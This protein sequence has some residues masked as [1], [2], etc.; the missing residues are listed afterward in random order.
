MLTESINFN[1][2]QWQS[3]LPGSRSKIFQQNGRQLRLVEFTSEFIEPDWC[4]KGHIGFVL[5]GILE[6]DFKGH[7]VIYPK[8]SGI[9]IPSGTENAHKAR[10]L[11]PVAQLILVEELT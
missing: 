5:E 9:F 10:S 6:I 2:I 11:T 8:G 7:I 3:T 4:V 1:D